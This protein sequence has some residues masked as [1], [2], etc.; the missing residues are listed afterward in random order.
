[1]N[2]LKFHWLTFTNNCMLTKSMY[3]NFSNFVISH[4]SVDYFPKL[5]PGF[6]FILNK[7]KSYTNSKFLLLTKFYSNSLFSAISSENYIFDKS[8]GDYSKPSFHLYF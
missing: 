8:I 4:I 3:K 2:Y 1:M 5:T 6:G 7:F